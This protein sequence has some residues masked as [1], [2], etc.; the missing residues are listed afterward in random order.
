[1]YVEEAADGAEHEA[2]LVEACDAC[3]GIARGAADEVRAEELHV[4]HGTE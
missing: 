4:G 1:M 3:G 2:G